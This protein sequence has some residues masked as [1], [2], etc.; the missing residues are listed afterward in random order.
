MNARWPI[1][2][3]RDLSPR[4]PVCSRSRGASPHR[5]SAGRSSKRCRR[6]RCAPIRFGSSISHRA[7][8]RKPATSTT[9]DERGLFQF[10]GQGTGA[11]RLEFGL[12]ASRLASSARVEA[13]TR[14]TVI[15][16]RFRVPVLELGGAQAFA[17]NEVQEVAHSRTVVPFRYPKEMLS[18]GMTGEV[19]A[20]FIVD[21]TGERSARLRRRVTVESSGVRA[22]RH[23]GAAH[24]E[25]HSRPRRRDSRVRSGSSNRSRFPFCA[26]VKPC[27]GRA[28]TRIW[29]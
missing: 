21:P 22:S 5:P 7:I 12:S 19:V 13:S 2:S 15:A 3:Q 18:L 4:A 1:E 16:V 24:D 17:S 28:R 26:P 23:R 8:R 20:R 10:G 9:T 29:Q 27:R 11:Y 6:S 25:L 14:D